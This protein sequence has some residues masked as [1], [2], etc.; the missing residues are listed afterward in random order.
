MNRKNQIL[1]TI[2]LV[3]TLTSCSNTKNT[4]Q[5]PKEELSS[6][7]FLNS[8]KSN[9]VYE[10]D[11]NAK[12]SKSVSVSV[13]ESEDDFDYENA[14]EIT[15]ADLWL[16]KAD[17]DRLTLDGEIY[18]IN[19]RI[20]KDDEFSHI[21][22]SY[23]IAILSGEKV[24]DL[25]ENNQVISLE[26]LI[27]SLEKVWGEKIA[28]DGYVWYSDVLLEPEN[29]T[30]IDNAKYSDNMKLLCITAHSFLADIF[31]SIVCIYDI[32]KNTIL[33]IK[34]PFYGK[35]SFVEFNGDNEYIAFSYSTGGDSLTQ[36]VS[37]L[38]SETMELI[39]HLNV[40]EYI[41]NLEQLEEGQLFS[42]S[43]SK[44]YWDNDVLKLDVE[45]DNSNGDDYIENMGLTIWHITEQP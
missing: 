24:F 31:D 32:E 38:K 37:V 4:N 36:Y 7:S 34:D 3:L 5:S 6:R 43:L 18:T 27:D 1:I 21:S 29:F 14:I 22:I 23:P 8:D 2:I 28:V 20:L 35:V 45:Y 13:S 44:M 42:V 40:N 10:Q 15:G 33:F 30:F 25:I 12:E 41:I 17:L 11:D 39:T 16:K 9:N 26:S 19:P